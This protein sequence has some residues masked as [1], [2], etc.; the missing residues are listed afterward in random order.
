MAKASKSLEVGH[1]L[2]CE[3]GTATVSKVIDGFVIV[4]IAGQSFEVADECI[5]CKAWQF[6][7]EFAQPL[8]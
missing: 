8:N 7:M 6:Q 1:T 4:S 2:Q 3:A 5:D